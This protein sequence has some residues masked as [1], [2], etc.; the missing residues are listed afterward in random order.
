MQ[1]TVEFSLLI[2]SEA[3]SVANVTSV[4]KY[5]LFFLNVD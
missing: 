3:S 5:P 4:F 2:L 1:D